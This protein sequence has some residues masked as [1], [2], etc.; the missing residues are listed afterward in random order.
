MSLLG[1]LLGKKDR[2]VEYVY[3]PYPYPQPVLVRPPRVF[4]RAEKDHWKEMRRRL[5][6]TLEDAKETRQKYG[7]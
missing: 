5:T 1:S 2:E 4:S 3:V 6:D 7:G